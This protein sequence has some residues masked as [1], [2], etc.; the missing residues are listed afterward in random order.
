ML[1]KWSNTVPDFCLET[2]LP[3]TREHKP[4]L[5]LVHHRCH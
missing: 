5:P 4:V 2:T 1:P 3:V